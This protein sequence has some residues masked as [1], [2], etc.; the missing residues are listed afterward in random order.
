MQFFLDIQSENKTWHDLHLYFKKYKGCDDGAYAEGYS[1]FVVHRLA[2]HWEQINE[3]ISI[4]NSDHHFGEFIIHHIDP[5]AGSN[6][7]SLLTTNAKQNCPQGQNAFCSEVIA[8]AQRG[9]KRI[10]EDTQHNRGVRQDA[11]P[12]GR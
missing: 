2:K 6:E 8:A 12:P 11:A 9:L 7:L 5:T 10:E 1:D 3:L 4:M